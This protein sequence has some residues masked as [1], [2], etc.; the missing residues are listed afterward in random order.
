MATTPAGRAEIPSFLNAELAAFSEASAT[1]LT[2]A[3][4]IFLPMAEFAA[5]TRL[6]F[7]A[8]STTFLP[9]AEFMTFL[10][11]AELATFEN[12]SKNLPLD[13]QNL[14]LVSH[15]RFHPQLRLPLQVPNQFL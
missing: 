3:V 6:S 10:V 11:R 4:C 13:S 8:F 14:S 2:T 15:R 12:M 7:V 9:I 1:P 5:L